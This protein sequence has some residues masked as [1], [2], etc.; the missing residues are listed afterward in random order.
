MKI[1][2][3]TNVVISGIFFGGNPRKILEAVVSHELKASATTEIVSEYQEIVDEMIQ[4]KQGHLHNDLLIPFIN[5]LNL[6]IPG[7]TTNICRDPDDNK[8][9]SCAK[10]SASLFIVS[11][12][13]DLLDLQSFE[14]VQIITAKEFVEKYL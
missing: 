14:G 5:N 4:R 8:F 3:D 6:I 2:I 9:L 12:D 1:V 10:D 13:K 11:G 7:T